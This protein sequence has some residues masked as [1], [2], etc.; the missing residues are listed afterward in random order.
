VK[1]L[2]SIVLPNKGTI[3]DFCSGSEMP[4]RKM[5]KSTYSVK[6]LR[7]ASGI[8]SESEDPALWFP[9]D[10]AKEKAVLIPEVLR[11]KEH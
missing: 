1:L 3:E 4:H 2:I 7:L 9:L 6:E 8:A 5:L 10:L 11:G